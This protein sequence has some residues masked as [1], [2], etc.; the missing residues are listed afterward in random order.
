MEEAIPAFITIYSMPFMYSISEGI[1]SGVI[2]YTALHILTGKTDK[3]TALM[4]IL[5]VLFILKYVFL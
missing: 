1:C 4:Y 3:L 5:T 2:A